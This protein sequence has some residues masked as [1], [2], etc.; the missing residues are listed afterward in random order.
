[1]TACRYDFG[2]SGLEHITSAVGLYKF[3]HSC[4]ALGFPTL[5]HEM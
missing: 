3:T 5:E 2:P 1:M 4:K